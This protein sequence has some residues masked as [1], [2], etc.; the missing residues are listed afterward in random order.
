MPSRQEQVF[1]L[2]F[3][4]LDFTCQK[5]CQNWRLGDHAFLLPSPLPQNHMQRLPAWPTPH[6]PCSPGK[7][8]SLYKHF[9][10][11]DVCL[12]ALMCLKGFFKV[13][14]YL[15]W[16]LS[17]GFF[18]FPPGSSLG[19]LLATSIFINAVWHILQYLLTLCMR[20]ISE[21]DLSRSSESCRC[22]V[23]CTRESL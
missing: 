6:L 14:W 20:S 8:T 18:H 1:N 15:P 17:V 5:L 12:R 10:S 4:L 16:V 2:C 21:R 23:S 9:I 11:F 13:R 19:T 22:I 3:N 7:Y